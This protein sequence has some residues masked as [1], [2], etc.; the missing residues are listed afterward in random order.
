MTVALCVVCLAQAGALTYA[1]RALS[2]TVR[3]Q[4]QTAA[5]ERAR[6]LDRIQAPET[7]AA[8]V[9]AD[10][11]DL[12]AGIDPEDD[13]AFNRNRRDRLWLAG[14]DAPAEVPDPPIDDEDLTGVA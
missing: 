9:V 13:E 1:F 12:L 2:R 4:E 6:L 5:L 10:G 11:A 8:R 14:E 3:E 7:V